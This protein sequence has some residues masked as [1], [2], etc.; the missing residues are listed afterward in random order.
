MGRPPLSGAPVRMGSRRT[1]A[2]PCV[3]A[4][5]RAPPRQFDDPVSLP[6]ARPCPP[7]RLERSGEGSFCATSPSKLYYPF[8]PSMQRPPI[9]ILFVCLGNICRSPLAEG[10]FLHLVRRAGVEDL[11]EVDS[12]GT[13]GYHD[14]NPPDAR[15][16]A[17]AL[18]RGVTLDGQSRRLLAED[19]QTFDYVIGMDADN[20]REIRALADEFGVK[21]RLHLLRE[22]DPQSRG[23]GVPDPY[24]G[25]ERGFDEVHDIVERCCEN[26]LEHL[27]AELAAT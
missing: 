18:A 17:T 1:I 3:P 24:Y 9:R 2:A 21:A 14:G 12:A 25:G 16:T 6:S 23:A 15:S 19:L 26:L 22:W 8:R 10:I 4:P 7:P 27:M 11:F 20:M 13:S 5:S